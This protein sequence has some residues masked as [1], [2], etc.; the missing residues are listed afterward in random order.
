MAQGQTTRNVLPISDATDTETALREVKR[1]ADRLPLGAAG[2]QV[3]STS[4]QVI[5]AGILSAISM[6]LVVYNKEKWLDP[7]NTAQ[8]I[9]PTGLSGVY[10]LHGEAYWAVNVSPVFVI[11]QVNGLSIAQG[12]VV[13]GN[14]DR[15]CATAVW[16]L[17]ERDIVNLAVFN[18]TAAP[19]T[20]TAAGGDT[21]SYHLPFLSAWRIS[22]L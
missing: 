4:N 6:G 5:P 20:V 7:S 8:F 9:V 3:Y 11:I 16:P 18:V 12:V 21:V 1:W 14:T 15:N 10:A 19:I 22:L 13:A 2:F 17:K